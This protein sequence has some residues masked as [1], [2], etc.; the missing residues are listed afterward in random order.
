MATEKMIVIFDDVAKDP[1]IAPAII[2]LDTDTIPEIGH[3]VS[4][5]NHPISVTAVV[6]EIRHNFLSKK[7]LA[8]VAYAR[9]KS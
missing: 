4:Y 1:T 3:I 7:H 2:A 8:I 9:K 5:I 6:E